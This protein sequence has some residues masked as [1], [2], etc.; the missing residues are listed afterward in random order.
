MLGVKLTINKSKPF[1]INKCA[2]SLSHIWLFVTP[3]NVAHQY[4]L[5][6]GILQARILEWVAMLSSRESSQLRDLTQVSY[7][8]G[9]FFINWTT[10]EAQEFWGG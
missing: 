10:T 7:T 4:P 8:A 1:H 3:W 6:M 9:G 2:E 5:F